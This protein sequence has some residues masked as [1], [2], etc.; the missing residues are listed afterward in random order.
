ML[1]GQGAYPVLGPALAEI[2][3]PDGGIDHSSTHPP[4]AFLF[5]LP[6]AEVPWPRAARMWAGIVL[7]ALLLAWRASGLGWSAA[8]ALTAWGLLWPPM[9]WSFSQ[10]TPLWLLG[11]TVAW[12]YH[13]R[14]WLAGAAVAVA[15]LTKFLPAILLVPFLLRRQWGALAGFATV[16]ALAVGLLLG[17]SPGVFAEYAELAMPTAVAIS[18]RADNGAL[19]AFATSQIGSPAPALAMGMILATLGRAVRTAIAGPRLGRHAWGLWVWLG[20]ALLPVS[21]QYSLLPLAAE[22]LDVIRRGE[23]VPRL[24]SGAALLAPVVLPWD[25]DYSRNGEGVVACLVLAGMALATTSGASV[26]ASS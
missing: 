10:L 8:F 2:G 5:G 17:L 21:W 19:L 15:S 25:A 16:W 11:Q 3:L 12:R 18:L 13:H 9:A 24:L 22:L 6:V 4:S 14:P 20:V 26:E 23:V 1:A 7:V